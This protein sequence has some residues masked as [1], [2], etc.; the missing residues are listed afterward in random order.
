M[1]IVLTQGRKYKAKFSNVIAVLAKLEFTVVLSTINSNF[2]VGCSSV[3]E[4]LPNI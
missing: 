4:D 1:L 3:T 2:L